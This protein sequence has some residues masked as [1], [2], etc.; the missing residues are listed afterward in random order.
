[1]GGETNILKRGQAR[2]GVG[3]LKGGAG[4][5]LQT[6]GMFCFII[7]EVSRRVFPFNAIMHLSLETTCRFIHLKYFITSSLSLSFLS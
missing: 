4:T 6:M 1:M 3:A 2:Q 7:V 5:P